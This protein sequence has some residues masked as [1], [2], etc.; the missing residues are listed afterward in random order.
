[1][2]KNKTF[3]GID[4]SKEKFDVYSSN[5]EFMSFS[6][7]YK[8]YKQL[9]KTL[10]EDGHLVMEATGYYHY[11]LAYYFQEKGVKV[12]VE[13]PLSVK[14]FIQMKLTKEKTDKSDARMI[15]AYAKQFSLT[16][17]KGHS[18]HQ[19][20]CLQIIR[21]LDQYTKQSTAIKNKQDGERALGNPCKIVDK[22]LA[23]SL[24]NIKKEII[25]LEEEL[26]T[27][28]KEEY[29]ELLTLVESIPG[30]GRKTATML[31]VLTDGFNRFETAKELCSY[32]GITP[33]IRTSGTSVNGRP[34]IS[35]MGNRKLRNLLFMCSFTAY[36][37]NKACKDIYDRIV[38][39]GKSKKLALLAV[40]NK[41][42]K[43]AF[44]IAKSGV[45]YD[46]TYRSELKRII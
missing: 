31:L 6:N 1:M 46:V 28:V 8:G 38:A 45:K 17:W 42:L 39:K 40:C 7:D 24:K 22:S 23:R 14:R 9:E 4:I 27:M 37:C 19:Q 36:K 21:L 43:Q 29:Q 44:A 25:F 26:I 20:E 12:Y 41:L 30:I 32:A 15:C 10:A 18:K 3:Y 5:D 35:K 33:I 11:K 13:H 2:S 34:R 16:E